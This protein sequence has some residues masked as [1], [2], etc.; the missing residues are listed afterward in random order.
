MKGRRWIARVAPAVLAFFLAGVAVRRPGVLVHH[1]AGGAEDHVHADVDAPDHGPDHD[2]GDDDHHHHGAGLAP[3]ES[4]LEAPDPTDVWHAHWQHPFQLAAREAVPRPARSESIAAA[5]RPVPA[6]PAV[7]PPRR[8][9]AR[10]PPS[11]SR[12]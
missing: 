2:D 12:S 1:H 10:A 4:A 8:P 11:P 6:T 9:E 3:G 7:A 5:A